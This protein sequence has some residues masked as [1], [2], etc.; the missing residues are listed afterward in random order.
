M[1][2]NYTLVLIA[3]LLASTLATDCPINT[4]QSKIYSG[5]TSLT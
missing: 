4:K 3:V 5:T 2:K 1:K